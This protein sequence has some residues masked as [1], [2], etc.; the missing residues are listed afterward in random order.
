MMQS[1]TIRVNVK[2]KG[3]LKKYIPFCSYNCLLLEYT[4]MF[5]VFCVEAAF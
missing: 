5:L 1:A 4:N 2:N 3:K